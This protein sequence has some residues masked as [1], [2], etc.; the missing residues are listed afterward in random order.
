MESALRPYTRY[1]TNLAEGK[2]DK[3]FDPTQ[4]KSWNTHLGVTLPSGPMLLLHNL[5]N[6]PDDTRLTGIFKS[7]TVLVSR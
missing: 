1:M 2:L 4:L 5:G 3:Y 7:E 6:F